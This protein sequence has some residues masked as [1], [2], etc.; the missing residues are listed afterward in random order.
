MFLKNEHELENGEKGVAR[1]CEW[2]E[3]KRRTK[4]SL[5]KYQIIY[6]NC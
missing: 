5:G 6:F 4:G 2:W 1:I 3:K